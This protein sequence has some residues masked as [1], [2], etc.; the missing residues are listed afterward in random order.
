LSD[1]LPTNI[2]NFFSN[3]G[4]TNCLITFGYVI[5]YYSTTLRCDLGSMFVI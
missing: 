1:A 3:F 5:I 2:R 4:H